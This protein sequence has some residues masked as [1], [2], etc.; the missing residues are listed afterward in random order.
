TNTYLAPLSTTTVNY[1]VRATNTYGAVNSNTAAVSVG[2]APPTFDLNA[3]GKSDI[4]W[5][6]TSTGDNHVSFMNGTGTVSSSTLLPANP[7]D[8]SSKLV[9]VGDLDGDGKPDLVWRNPTNG[10]NYVT[11]MN[12]T[13]V[14]S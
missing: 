7:N 2:P 5:R 8:A 14:A 12:G 1:W 13:T 11:H 3:D 10:N 6:N 9:A 4:V